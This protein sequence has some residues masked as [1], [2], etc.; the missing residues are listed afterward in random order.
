ML[1]TKIIKQ[2]KENGGAS[3]PTEFRLNLSIL[4]RF[5]FL[6]FFC[7]TECHCTKSPILQQIIV[8]CD[9][10]R[11]WR[12]VVRV[13]QLFEVCQH[14]FANLSLPCEGRFFFFINKK[15]LKN[16]HENMHLLTCYAI[17]NAFAMKG[18]IVAEFNA[19]GS[20]MSLL[21]KTK[22]ACQTSHENKKLSITNFLLAIQRQYF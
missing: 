6:L 14:E 3:R 18:Q 15:K 11:V 21:A 20:L 10:T 4:H 12:V 2:T 13:C 5:L 1:S 16:S 17:G 9:L 19:D 22:H 8:C 7:F